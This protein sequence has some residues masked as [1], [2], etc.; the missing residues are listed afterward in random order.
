LKE[1]IYVLELAKDYDPEL[2]RTLRFLTKFD[3]FDS[4]DTTAHVVG[5]IKEQISSKLGAHDLVCRS[6]GGDYD[7]K[8]E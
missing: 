7:T 6:S 2:D 8:E 5:L 4:P 1:L 3:T